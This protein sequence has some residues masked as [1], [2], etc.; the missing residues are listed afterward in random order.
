MPFPPPLY[1]TMGRQL[2]G[3]SGRSVTGQVLRRGHRDLPQIGTEPHGNHVTLDHFTDADRCIVASGD[4]VDDLIVQ[5]D[6]EYHIRTGFA[7]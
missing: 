5:G 6:I 1:T 4:D 7:E 3:A 2:A